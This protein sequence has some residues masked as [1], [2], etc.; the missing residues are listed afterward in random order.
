MQLWKKNFLLTFSMF[1]IIFNIGLFYITSQFSEN[2][3]QR[4]VETAISE[5]ESIS[6]TFSNIYKDDSGSRLLDYLYSQ[7]SR[8]Q[9]YLKIYNGNKLIK[10]TL[11][12][13]IIQDNNKIGIEKIANSKYIC[14][15]NYSINSPLQI[16]FM[17]DISFLTQK[18]QERLLSTLVV[19]FLL[20]LFVGIMLYITMKQ[21]N[22]P[23]SNISHELRTPL[24]NIQGYAQYLMTVKTSEE[25]RFFASEYI[26][27]EARNMQEIIDKLLIMGNIREGEINKT[28]IS[29]QQL[30]EELAEEY[31]NVRIQPTAKNI[32]GDKMLIQTLMRNLISNS[33]RS[34]GEIILYASESSIILENKDD[35]IDK[36]I[37]KALNK[38]LTVKAENI[39]GYGQG[40]HLCHEIM[41]RHK[42]SLVYESTQKKG[43]KV[44]V[45]F[46]PLLR[47]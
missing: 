17:K 4:E 6:Y 32:Y 45:I 43:T 36:D 15:T 37:L 10:S 8:D 24:T 41:K 22:K 31:P 5:Y 44:E 25:E 46:Y 30:F 2:E 9:I 20:S 12:I 7:Y 13:D 40:V 34:G 19:D 33:E 42:G 39:H 23:V 16:T 29:L 28:K 1:L 3:L 27:K 38:N 35:F 21:I 11:P 47:N 14:I 26:L 18:Q